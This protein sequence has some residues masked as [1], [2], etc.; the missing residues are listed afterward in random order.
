MN[1]VG[2]SG[3]LT[4]TPELAYTQ[5][6]IPYCRFTVASRRPKTKDKT[7]FIRCIAW[8]GTAEFIDRWF[9]KGSRIE[10]SGILISNTYEDANG[11]TRS[12]IEVLVN[13]AQFG[14]RKQTNNEEP[15]KWNKDE[16]R[17]NGTPIS[18]EEYFPDDGDIP[19]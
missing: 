11:N 10:V 14:D 2:L 8:R 1:I 13:D 4:A 6:D 5:D 17:R 16:D 12:S 18:D 7:D 3:N 9:E 15:S 19:F